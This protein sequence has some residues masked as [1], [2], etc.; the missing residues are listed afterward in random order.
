MVSMTAQAKIPR[1]R[2]W[3]MAIRPKTLPAAMSPVVMGI[4]L[5]IGAQAF[6]FVPA[7]AALICALLLQIGTNLANDYFD[8]VKGSDIEGRKGPQRVAQSGLIPLHEL[9]VGIAITFSLAMLVGLYLVAVGG[10]PIL[11]I[12]I[13]SIA[14]ALAYTGGPFPL[15]Y[16][17][18]GDLFVFLYFGL[19]GVCGTFY[20]QAQALTVQV[21]VAAI[22]VGA[23]T[24]AILVVNNLRDVETDRKTGKRTLAV[25]MGTR[26]TR[27]EYVLLLAVAY[28]T[29]LIFWLT[30]WAAA[31]VLLPWLTLPLGWR[32]VRTL[33]E[34]DEGA[35]LNRALAGTANLDLL[36][37]LLFAVGLI[38]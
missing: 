7:G 21:V 15:G 9:R 4:A 5:A 26:K 29:P 17:G 11:F 34:T 13:T 18:L 27:L 22:A 8:Y 33:Y 12:G 28:A 31:W 19:A 16:H 32:L 1:W 2:A 36:F 25:M 30:N 3:L 37:S 20:V 6:V 35:R 10:W 38:L 24:V 23:L 14:A